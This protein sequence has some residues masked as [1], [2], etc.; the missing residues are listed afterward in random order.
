MAFAHSGREKVE[1]DSTSRTDR[2]FASK[3]SLSAWISSCACPDSP[4]LG[5]AAEFAEVETGLKTVFNDSSAGTTW[6][7]HRR[8]G[9]G[10]YERVLEKLCSVVHFRNFD[11]ILDDG[12]QRKLKGSC[13]KLVR[14]SCLPFYTGED[15]L[16]NRLWVRRIFHRI[17]ELGASRIKFSLQIFNYK[18]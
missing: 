10:E 16:E 1:L 17:E 8:W 15:E 5:R 2:A 6:F 4:S 3:R 12:S 14:F 11:G 13:C 7:P 18:L 9:R